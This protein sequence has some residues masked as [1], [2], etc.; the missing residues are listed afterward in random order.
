MILFAICN[1]FLFFHT[2]FDLWPDGSSGSKSKTFVIPARDPKGQIQGRL[3]VTWNGRQ[4]FDLTFV[5]MATLMLKVKSN[6]TV[7]NYDTVPLDFSGSI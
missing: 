4:N 1:I 5:G 3:E 2:H 6:G 7:S